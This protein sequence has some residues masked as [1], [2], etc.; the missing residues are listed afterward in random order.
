MGL[1]SSDRPLA[2]VSL[3]K[4]L[5][6]LQI[7]KEELSHPCPGIRTFCTDLLVSLLELVEDQSVF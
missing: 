2:K 4:M 5:P 6:T 3:G 1:A 7:A